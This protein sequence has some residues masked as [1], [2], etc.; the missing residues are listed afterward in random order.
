MQGS[1]LDES[2]ASDGVALGDQFG[3][4][5]IDTAPA[6]VVDLETLHDADF[7]IGAG[8]RERGDDAFGHAVAAVGRN[9]HGD[10]VAFRCTELPV[11]DVVDRCAGS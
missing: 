11:V 9:R 4:G 10:P 8:D 7:A 6:E 2:E 3:G 5:C 1:W